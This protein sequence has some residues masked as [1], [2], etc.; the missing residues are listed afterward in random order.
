ML[1]WVPTVSS[2]WEVTVELPNGTSG[3]YSL[4]D[5]K[6]NFDQHTITGSLEACEVSKVLMCDRQLRCS[7]AATGGLT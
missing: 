7:A 6:Q 4:A 1:R 2:E 3:N 5:L